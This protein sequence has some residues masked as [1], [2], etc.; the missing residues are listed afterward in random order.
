VNSTKK[1]FNPQIL[2]VIVKE[3]NIVSNK[4]KVL[5][6]WSEFYKKHFELQ[7]GADNDSEEECTRCTQ[8]PEQYANLIGGITMC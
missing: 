5:Q 3:G 6:R 8:T 4:E 7:D 1:Y 2:L